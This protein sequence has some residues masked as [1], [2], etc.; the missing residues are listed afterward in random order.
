MAERNVLQ[1]QTARHELR[2]AVGFSV[3]DDISNLGQLKK[4][5]SIGEGK[6]VRP[7]ATQRLGV[8]LASFGSSLN[9]MIAKISL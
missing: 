9:Q 1:A 4:A 6:F 7:G 8:R 5:G 2:R 3:A